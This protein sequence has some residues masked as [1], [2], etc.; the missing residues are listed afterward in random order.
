MLHP[1]VELEPDSK[2]Q[3]PHVLPQLAGNVNPVHAQLPPWHDVL[4]PH[5]LL[6]PPQLLLSVL[7]L[8]QLLQHLPV[9]H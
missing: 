8:T 1:S 9:V 4:A 5:L 6:Q 2:L 3:P 7:A